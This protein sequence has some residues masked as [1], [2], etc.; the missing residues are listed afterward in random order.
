MKITEIVPEELSVEGFKPFGVAIMEP[1]D[2][3][4]REGDNWKCW[5]G[6][7]DLSPGNSSLGIVTVSWNGAPVDEMEAHGHRELLM[8]LKDPIIQAVAIPAD[9]E[10]INAQP[11]VKDIKAFI[12]RP[13]QSIMMEVGTWHCAAVPVDGRNNLLLH[14]QF[15]YIRTGTHRKPLGEIQE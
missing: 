5:V 2:P 15:R 11:D 12:V 3:A 4:G 1:G 9:M 7:E 6:V 13:G 8:P 14:Y 10:D